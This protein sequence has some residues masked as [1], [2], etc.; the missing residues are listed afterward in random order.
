[1]ILTGIVHHKTKT[2]SKHQFGVLWE[3][4]TEGSTSIYSLQERTQQCFLLLVHW[5]KGGHRKGEGRRAKAPDKEQTASHS[6][7][8]R[9][10][11]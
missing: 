4:S 6:V 2:E 10:G 9:I 7:L 3:P 11:N 5:E 8:I 1:M